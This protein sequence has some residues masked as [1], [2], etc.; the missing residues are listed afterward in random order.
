MSAEES[1]HSLIS[2]L[3]RRESLPIFVAATLLIPGLA[4]QGQT[5]SELK[6]PVQ[7]ANPIDPLAHMPEDLRSSVE[8]VVII[9][10]PSPAKESV[11]GTY[12]K[13]TAGLVGGM[14]SGSRIGTINTEIGGVAVDFPI[15]ILTIPG[16]IYG[17]L[18]GAAKREIQEFRDELTDELRKAESRSLTNE[19]LALEVYSG[20]RRLPKPD[21]KLFAATTPIPDDT[22]AILYVSFSDLTIDVQEDEAIITTSAKATLRRL[23]DGSDLYEKTIKYQ[24]RDTLSSWTDNGNALWQDYVNFTRH[25]LGREISAEVFSRIKPQH[26]MRAKKT[27]TAARDKKNEL[28][29]VS[30]SLSPTLAWELILAEDNTYG[31]WTGTIDE[32]D[33]YYDV[34]IYDTHRPVYTE[35][36]IPEPS[37]TV[38]IELEACKTY[39]WS[40]RPSF[41]VDGEIKYGEWMRFVPEADVDTETT[42][43][44]EYGIYGRKA[45]VAPAYIQD[46]ALLEIRCG[47]R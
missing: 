28:K 6:M 9:A 1:N 47:R 18:T 23:S 24:D 43:A 44:T 19:G 29:F 7:Q 34:E 30:K 17:G 22:D 46:F 11:T 25:Y 2:R 27:D 13:E 20:L 33:I 3:V 16:A 26:E 40:V 5:G 32:A 21:S 41:H 37:H 38:A 10:G 45:S 12:D 4:V 36:Q 42:K 8:K 31:S 39:R 14:N 35:K 15:P